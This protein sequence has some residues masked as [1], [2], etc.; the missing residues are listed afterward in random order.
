MGKN[1]ETV[2]VLMGRHLNTTHTFSFTGCESLWFVAT[3]SFQKENKTEKTPLQDKMMHSFSDLFP[4]TQ[5]MGISA[6]CVSAFWVWVK[7][8]GTQYG[9]HAYMR[10]L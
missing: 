1:G 9:T 5:N 8:V 7:A 2:L 6:N 10:N 4:V 3:K